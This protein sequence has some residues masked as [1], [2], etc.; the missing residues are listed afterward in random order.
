MSEQRKKRKNK[1]PSE[2]EPKKKI[3]SETK[4][5]VSDREVSSNWK[6]LCSALNIK[7]RPKKAK[8]SNETNESEKIWFEIDGK[9]LREDFGKKK[10]VETNKEE[11]LVKEK[12]FTGLTRAVSMDCEMVGVGKDGEQSILARA[13]IVNHFGHCIYDKYVKPTEKVTNYRTSVSGIRPHHLK[14]GEDFKT[15]QKE[16]FEIIKGRI[17]VGHAIKHD[18]QVLFLDHPRK[19]IR[20]TSRYFK[21]ISGGKTPS[22]RRLSEQLLGVGIQSGEHDSVEDARVAMRLY[23]M[24]RKAWESSVKSKKVKAKVKKTN[25]GA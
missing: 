11:H 4:Y 5:P 9:T 3:K 23:T 20:D 22:L 18:L 19:D 12:S 7:S 6:N 16:V 17:L 2:P 13:S 24:H 15:V 21:H 8:Q 25:D 1:V 10:I 14:D